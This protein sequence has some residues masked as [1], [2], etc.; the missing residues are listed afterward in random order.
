MHAH[1]HAHVIMHN[2]VMPLAALRY[3]YARTHACE[4]ARLRTSNTNRAVFVAAMIL[5]CSWAVIFMQKIASPPI[6]NLG[7]TRRKERRP[8][9]IP[10]P[11]SM[12]A[13]SHPQTH[14]HAIT[15]AC[16]IHT[17]ITFDHSVMLLCSSKVCICTKK[18]RVCT[19][20]HIPASMRAHRH[21]QTHA[22]AITLACKNTHMH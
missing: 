5:I 16:K 4:Y 15:L 14:A 3:A 6:A 8:T 11:A 18:L 2:S 13:H 17:C 19:T 12:H 20:T 22:H 9:A 10:S 21:A 1:I 7:C